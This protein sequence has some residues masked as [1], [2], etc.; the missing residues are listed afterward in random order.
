MLRRCLEREELYS[1]TNNYSA[2]V[3]IGDFSPQRHLTACSRCHK[4]GMPTINSPGAA[5]ADVLRSLQPVAEQVF[6]N[7]AGIAIQKRS[8]KK[9]IYV[10]LK[11]ATA[12][13]R[14]VRVRV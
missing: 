14:K 5:I 3:P 12:I 1:G 8:I 13:S 9:R 10:S 4:V 7:E 11:K 2:S 6:K